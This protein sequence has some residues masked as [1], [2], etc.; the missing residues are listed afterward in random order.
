[1]L[2]WLWLYRAIDAWILIAMGMGFFESHSYA[3]V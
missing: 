3:S 1:M 2:C